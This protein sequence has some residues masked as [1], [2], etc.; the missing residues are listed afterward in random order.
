MWSLK[1]SGQRARGAS[2][3][4]LKY[5]IKN[6]SKSLWLLNQEVCFIIKLRW[7]VSAESDFAYK[8]LRYTFTP[9]LISSWNQR[10]GLQKPLIL[11]A[12]KMSQFI[13]KSS[14][15]YFWTETSLVCRIQVYNINCLYLFSGIKRI[16]YCSVC[17]RESW[18]S[19]IVREEIKIRA[20]WKVV[21]T[22]FHC[23]WSDINTV[24]A[25]TCWQFYP[26][27]LVRISFTRILR[28]TIRDIF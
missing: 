5:V 15:F 19:C 3:S 27:F 2:V 20:F 7:P 16:F 6:K 12:I 25:G 11:C 4:K 22:S 18:G 9:E 1:T 21:R 10:K 24:N 26:N 14:Q 28:L 23:T 13:W 17:R 8:H